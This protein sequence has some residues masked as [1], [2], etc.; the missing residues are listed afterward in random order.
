MTDW[1][2]LR[3]AM[4]LLGMAVLI[5]G[6]CSITGESPPTRLYML[7]PASEAGVDLQFSAESHYTLVGVDPVEFPDYL[8][9]SQLVVRQGL[10]EYALAEFDRWAESL[11][12]NFQRVLLENLN[13]L[14]R[15]APLAVIQWRRYLDIDYVL[16]VKVTRL[17]G[18]TD[19]NVT[20]GVTWM[21]F[22]QAGD[23]LV[24]ARVSS[25]TEK[26]PPGD[27]AALAAAQS[28]ALDAFSQD[29]A[30][31]LRVLPR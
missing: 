20:L 2:T 14:V 19:G 1:K 28:R 10:N 6:G 26:A 18:D 30:E 25:Y 4:P 9:R 7:T 27:Y 15:E 5:L 16:R 12:S 24:T 23:T 13:G 21:L 22:D 17:E 29:V 8:E 3:C 31:A 11:Q